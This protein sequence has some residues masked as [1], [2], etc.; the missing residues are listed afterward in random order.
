M[1]ESE[2]GMSSR[3]SI[4]GGGWSY[5]P[6]SL[7]VFSFGPMG[8][9]LLLDLLGVEYVKSVGRRMCPQWTQYSLYVKRQEALKFVTV[10]FFLNKWWDFTLFFIFYFQ[11]PLRHFVIEDKAGIQ[12]NSSYMRHARLGGNSRNTLNQTQKNSNISSGFKL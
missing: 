5:V 8:L 2:Y 12:S 10:F 7:S 4:M 9:K 1:T 3:S 6:I 11:N